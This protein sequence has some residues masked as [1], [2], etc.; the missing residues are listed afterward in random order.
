M[1]LCAPARHGALLSA[2]RVLSPA[3]RS[4]ALQTRPPRA[5][6]VTLL[7]TGRRAPPLPRRGA[8]GSAQLARQAVQVSARSCQRRAVRAGS[9][10]GGGRRA[11]AAPEL[12]GQWC[13]ARSPSAPP[14]AP[15]GSSPLPARRPPLPRLPFSFSSLTRTV[16]RSRPSQAC[17]APKQL[18]QRGRLQ[19]CYFLTTMH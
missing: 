12:A 3:H 1:L 4:R 8:G 15:A 7:G 16:I 5:R 9:S 13:C 10:R 14:P 6:R 2:S 17:L 19:C 11:G 18:L